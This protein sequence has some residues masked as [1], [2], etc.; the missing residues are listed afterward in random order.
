MRVYRLVLALVLVPAAALGAEPL[1][2]LRE[3]VD[4]GQME[5]AYELATDHVEDR[6][7]EPLFDLYYGIAAVETGNLDEGVFALER[8]LISRPGF[9]RARLEYAR[10]LY[11]QGDDLRARRQFEIVRS[12][13]PPPA[14]VDRLER[15]L[16]AINRRADRYETRIT[17]DVGLRLGHDDNI[18]RATDA[19]SVDTGLG[20]IQLDDESSAAE[21]TFGAV[22]GDVEVSHPLRPGLNI[23]AGLSGN[24]ERNSEDSDFNTTRAGGR[25]GLRWRT[26]PHR[27]SSFIRGQRLYVGGHPYQGA[28]VVDARY[29][30]RINEQLSAHATAS[31]TRLRYD[32][33][34]ALDSSLRLIGGGLSTSWS[35]AWNP[36]ARFTALVGDEEPEGD[37]Q[38]ADA[39]AHRDIWELRANAAVT[40]ASQWTLR[41]SLRFRDSEYDDNAFPFA[42]AREEEYASLDVALDWRPSMNWRLGPYLSYSDNDA[43]I[44]IYDYDR[45]VIGFETRYLFY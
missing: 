2:R 21:A 32:D 43:N 10:A 36:R 1:D 4:K 14:V 6:A 3:L 20:T 42:R 16:A 12:H 22:D 15:Y 31:W 40:P 17:G 7:G 26:G 33:L 23:L 25:V 28:G 11:L 44:G 8:V 37:S 34:E 35:A 19:D 45:T 38:R 5:A 39:L 13:D 27:V 41:G 30:Y 9:D 29:R 24:V 18:N